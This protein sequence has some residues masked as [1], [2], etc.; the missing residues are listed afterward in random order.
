MNLTVKENTTDIA[1]GWRVK[2]G[3]GDKVGQVWRE[4]EGISEKN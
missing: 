4:R 2:M 3:M 1:V